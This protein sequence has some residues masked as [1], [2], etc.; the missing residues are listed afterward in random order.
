MEVKYHPGAEKFLKSRNEPDYSRLKKAS[1][2]WAKN[3]RKVILYRFRVMKA[4]SDSE[5]AAIARFF[6]MIMT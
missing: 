4:S 3:R 1:M 6:T 2:V 5:K